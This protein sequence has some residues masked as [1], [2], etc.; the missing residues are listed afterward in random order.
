MVWQPPRNGCH[1]P[2]CL[3]A[4]GNGLCAESIGSSFPGQAISSVI[5][6]FCNLLHSLQ[7]TCS[8]AAKMTTA[9]TG[10]QG[11][12]MDD[13]HRQ[14]GHQQH[15]T[16]PVASNLLCL[17]LA[18]YTLLKLDISSTGHS[19]LPAICCDV[20]LLCTA[21]ECHQKRRSNVLQQSHKIGMHVTR[22][23]IRQNFAGAQLGSSAC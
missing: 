14:N 17:R 2:A 8:H 1:V 3:N 18:L 16:F 10:C 5:A 21:P 7:Q 13:E 22:I 12:A 23:Y 6:S 15:W 19:L 11:P 4:S 9:R 20:G